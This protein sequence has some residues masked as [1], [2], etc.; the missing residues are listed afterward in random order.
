MNS[1]FL[2][3]HK[4]LL[5]IAWAGTLV[6]MAAF[7]L[8]RTRSGI[9]I[10]TDILAL[11]PKTKNNAEV[12]EA[13]RR[14]T[15]K[16]GEKTVFLFGHQDFSTAKK[17]AAQFQEHLL[18][19]GKFDAITFR[20][21]DLGR[22]FY[23]YYQ[24][25]LPGLMRE[26]QRKLLR[27]NADAFLEQRRNLLFHPGAVVNSAL[28]RRDPLMLFH[29]FMRDLQQ[30]SG[31]VMIQ[32]GVAVVRDHEKQYVLV[33]LQSAKELFS[34][35]VQAELMGSIERGLGVVKQS[36]P[37]TT[38]L[39]A[40]LL[41]HAVAGVASAQG[42]ISLF[43]SISIGAIILLL[44]LAFNSIRPLILGVIPVAYGIIAAYCLSILF[45]DKIHV[46]TVVFGTSLI[47]ISIDYSFHYF[48][49]KSMAKDSWSPESGI[50]TIL[51]GIT[52]GLLTTILGF[53]CLFIAPLPVL[54][55]MALFATTGLVAAYVTVLFGLPLLMGKASWSPKS[56]LVLLSAQPL[57]WSRKFRYKRALFA[58]VCVLSLLG[59][60]FIKIEDDI[61][62]LKSTPEVLTQ[63]EAQI[64]K[65]L[66]Y[67]DRSRFVVTMGP[68]IE[69]VLKR[70]AQL[71]GVLDELQAT[72]ALV[73]Y[74][75]ISR[76]I[77]S[78]SE[79]EQ[80]RAAVD[81]YLVQAG[82]L[83]PYM[84]DLGFSPGDIAAAVQ[85][86]TPGRNNLL[87]FTEWLANPV[88]QPYRHLWLGELDKKFVSIVTLSDVQN[89][90][91]LRDAVVRLPDVA[92]VDRVAD[93]SGMFR[94][95]RLLA[96]LL[97]FLSYGAIYILLR[98]RYGWRQALTIML[99]AAFGALIALST[100]AATGQVLNLFNTLALLLI[101]GIGIDY[102]IFFQEARN[103]YDAV[104][105]ATFLSAVT[106]I[107]S[108]GLL[109][110]SAT[111]LLSAFGFTVAVG[112]TVVYLLS[113]FI[114]RFS[115]E[116]YGK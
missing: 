2:L 17:N 53:L 23:E 105:L 50:R 56:F 112:V 67:T 48:A 63:K 5:F 109:V 13:A 102:A 10:E 62:L 4:R 51:P 94:Y 31:G 97:V 101:L 22:R 19:E 11:L 49:D 87:K 34:A 83:S 79:Q 45:F 21:D 9:G 68:T 64:G 103:D 35:E 28:L 91:A 75:A 96:S 66:G 55:Q 98:I 32:D 8:W 106:T 72:G 110:F 26:S 78:Q 38:V 116:E 61:R 69:D 86:F 6:L 7:L 80:N 20:I 92:Y 90:V 77:P 37:E 81:K 89:E 57:I 33:T 82:K 88:S 47:G 27:N 60:V 41:F 59:L 95:Y 73:A 54:Q 15:E 70:E 18:K 40:G 3:S 100:L 115:A 65:L 85:R 44:F 84:R 14:F 113:P 99:P 114:I 52:L 74:Q 30:F 16:I 76:L 1:G 108:F 43:G 104:S 58:V 36:N 39:Y 71:V 42:E 12:E 93:I 29:E 111:P 25:S 46:I 107:L 24:D